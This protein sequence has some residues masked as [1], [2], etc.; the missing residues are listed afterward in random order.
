M[1]ALSVRCFSALTYFKN[2]QVIQCLNKLENFEDSSE[3]G[4]SPS[5][6]GPKRSILNK[7]HDELVTVNRDIGEQMEINEKLTADLDS[8]SGQYE[9]MEEELEATIASY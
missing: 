6:G 9:Q 2:S 5:K 3:D 8:L 7:M 4:M 1:I